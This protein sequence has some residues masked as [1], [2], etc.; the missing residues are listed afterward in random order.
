MLGAGDTRPGSGQMSSAGSS[1]TRTAGRCP[2]AGCGSPGPPAGPGQAP[3][4][5]PGTPGSA[6]APGSRR[7]PRRGRPCRP[8]PRRQPCPPARRPAGPA[9]WPD[10]RGRARAFR[11]WP[12]RPAAEQFRHRGGGTGD[13]GHPDRGRE[14]QLLALGQFTLGVHRRFQ[15]ISACTTGIPASA[16]TITFPPGSGPAA[17]GRTR[18][19]APSHLRSASSAAR[20][21]GRPSSAQ[22]SSSSAAAYPPAAT[23][24]AP[25][26]ATTTAGS[27]GTAA[28]TCWPPENWTGV[29]GKERPSSS[30]VRAAP[31]TIARTRVKPQ[32]GQ[33][34]LAATA[35]HHRH[36]GVCRAP[37]ISSWPEHT[38]QR[39]CAR[40]RPHAM[41][42]R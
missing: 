9:R 26:V 38:V 8:P 32:R 4:P 41:A 33:L 2:C 3:S 24:S 31:V 35:P 19:A 12:A 17:P 37:V 42:A 20:R 13:G 36:C 40:Q 16:C 22:P 15:R 21:L 7:P 23:G 27:P 25:G 30:A 29:D 10:R 28:M 39:A 6:R 14:R 34:Q 11:R 5:P 18:A 1:W